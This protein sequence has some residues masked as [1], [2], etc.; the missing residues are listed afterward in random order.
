MST[1]LITVLTAALSLAFAG[2]ASAGQAYD[3]VTGRPVMTVDSGKC[4]PGQTEGKKICT[5]D[6]SFL[7]TH[8]KNCRFETVA[9]PVPQEMSP[10]KA[11]AIQVARA[12]NVYTSD[13][14]LWCLRNGNI[15]YGSSGYYGYGGTISG[16]VYDCRRNGD[17]C[18][19]KPAAAVPDRRW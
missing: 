14:Y 5:C 19:R 8:Y 16:I 13:A 12:N 17:G 1:K 9:D 3:P 7:G 4:T 2:A 10:L 15:P 6:R 11:C 18:D